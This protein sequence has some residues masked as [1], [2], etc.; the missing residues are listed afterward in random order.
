[1]IP[2]TNLEPKFGQICDNVQK[3]NWTVVQPKETAMGPYAF[4]DNQWVGYDDD[5]IVRRKVSICFRRIPFS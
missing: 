3:G 4:K 2:V 5:A 1:M